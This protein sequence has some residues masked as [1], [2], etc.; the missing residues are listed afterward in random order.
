MRTIIGLTGVK[1]S[2]K[3][4]CFNA[5]KKVY[6]EARE[7]M[8]AGRLKNACSEVFGIP[9]NHFDDPAVKEKELEKLV[10]LDEKNTAA[11]IH[12]FG[13]QPDFDKHIRPHLNKVLHSPRQIAQYVG[14]E[15][16]RRVDELIHCKGAVLD[17]PHEG[18]FVVTDI[19]FWN[20]Y[21]FFDNNEEVRFFPFYI[22]NYAAEA[23]ASKDSHASEKYVL[24]IAKKCQK[25]DNNGSLPEFEGRVLDAVKFLNRGIGLVEEPA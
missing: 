21:D 1:G 25:I 8:L 24:E 15:V 12:F 9:R 22:S 10:V 19:R 20:E 3:T 14:T 13:E 5:I 18:V 2:G 16:L 11:L 4:T 17:L 23:V 6:P 7:I